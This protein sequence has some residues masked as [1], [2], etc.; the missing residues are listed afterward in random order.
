MLGGKIMI[1][2]NSA[3]DILYL[4]RRK[5]V[6]AVFVASGL[7]P[8]ALSWVF[9]TW[10]ELE[11]RSGDMWHVVVPLR[12]VPTHKEDPPD[13]T[14]QNFNVDLAK[15]FR[16][17]YGVSDGDTPTLVF[18]DFND[19]VQQRQ[20]SLKGD[21]EE[22][23][24]II[25][26]IETFMNAKV[27][28]SGEPAVFSDLGRMT[29]VGELVDYLAMQKIKRAAFRLVPKVGSALLKIAISQGLKRI[30]NVHGIPTT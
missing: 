10:W 23:K 18:D 25:R 21:E 9:N 2:I 1:P 14:H 4:E 7:D 19:E 15:K 20:V 27:A 3:S 11:A 5:Q 6:V 22:R 13:L 17:T 8:G 12:K 24:H 26:A 29:I 30:A 28:A 16:E